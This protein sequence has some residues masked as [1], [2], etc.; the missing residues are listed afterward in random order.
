MPRRVAEFESVE[1]ARR[2]GFQKRLQA[3][4]VHFPPGRQ[5]EHDG[6]QLVAQQVHA[7]EEFFDAGLRVLQLLHVREKAAT[8]GGEAEVRGRGVAPSDD[9]A[10]RRQAI[11]GVIQLDRME[12]IRVVVEHLRSG[13]FLGI[14][15]AEPVLVV[16]AGRPNVDRGAHGAAISARIRAASAWGSAARVS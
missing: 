7:R 15:R 3:G 9:A 5:L 1:A 2:Q 11:K 4:G 6:A 12:A 10:V 16:P 14:E 13:Q 8:L